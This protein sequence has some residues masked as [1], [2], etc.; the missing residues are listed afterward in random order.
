MAL[1]QSRGGLAGLECLYLAANIELERH[2]PHAPELIGTLRGPY[3]RAMGE[4]LLLANDYATK[5]S[6]DHLTKAKIAVA[7]FAG[8]SDLARKLLDEND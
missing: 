4:G 7:V 1:A 6:D 8:Q 5:L 2:A 3:E